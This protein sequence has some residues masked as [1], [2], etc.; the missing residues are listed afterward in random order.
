MILLSAGDKQ[1]GQFRP[2]RGSRVNAL[3]I[4]LFLAMAVGAGAQS[5]PV[6]P[7]TVPSEK[8]AQDSPK[9]AEVPELGAAAAK[10]I[11]ASEKPPVNPIQDLFDVTEMKRKAWEAVE[12]ASMESIKKVG[13]EDPCSK[14]IATY[15]EKAR[16]AFTAYIRA[17]SLYIDK[18]STQTQEAVQDLEDQNADGKKP[19]EDYPAELQ[20]INDQ[21]AQQQADLAKLPK[22][23]PTF[24]EAR[25]A[26]QKVIDLLLQNK[27]TLE[28]AKSD[29]DNDEDA[30]TA[31]KQLLQ[32]KLQEIAAMK[33]NREI[34]QMGRENMYRLWRSEWGMRCLAWTSKINTGK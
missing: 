31:Q 13:S 20:R 28:A 10:A 33:Q 12:A 4:P 16:T 25:E 24:T 22:D 26:T 29:S 15:T 18:W 23:N 5:Q 19:R 9:P 34:R 7:E 27:Q 14:R 2:I 30:R 3:I 11:A 6:K 21:I 1:G 32:A 8:P 17:Y